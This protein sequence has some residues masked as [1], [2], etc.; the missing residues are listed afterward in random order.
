VRVD[1]AVYAG[2]V[3]PPHYDSLI[4]KLI[5][6][7]GDRAEALARGR[8]ALE[9]FTIEGVKTTIPLHLSILEDPRFRKGEFSTKFMDDFLK[10]K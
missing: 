5:V 3:V 10:R 4:A 8:R 6:H 7:G 9:L 2:W 1:S